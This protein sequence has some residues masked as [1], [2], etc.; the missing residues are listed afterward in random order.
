MPISEV[1]REVWRI[2]EKLQR[3]LLAMTEAERQEYLD[4]VPQRAEAK[5]GRPLRLRY[6]TPVRSGRSP[7]TPVER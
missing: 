6:E 7:K 2:R 4:S 5:L 1:Q 3:K